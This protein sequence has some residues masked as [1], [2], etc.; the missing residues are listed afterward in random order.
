MLAAFYTAYQTLCSYSDQESNST[1]HYLLRDFSPSETKMLEICCED[2]GL[3]F[4][5]CSEY[6]LESQQFVFSSKTGFD[7][8]TGIV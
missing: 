8:S 1:L 3:Y 7:F 5:L 4:Y 2:D 6:L